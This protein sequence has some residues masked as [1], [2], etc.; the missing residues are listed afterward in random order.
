M[1]IIPC[2]EEIRSEEFVSIYLVKL[3]K[4][5]ALWRE[6]VKVDKESFQSG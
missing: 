4:F 1:N 6:D 3:R 5:L 2:L